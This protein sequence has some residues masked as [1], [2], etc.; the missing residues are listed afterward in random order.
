MQTEDDTE[1]MEVTIEAAPAP[2]PPAEKKPIEFWA[3]AKGYLPQIFNGS[4]YALP[5]GAP[6]DR[7]GGSAVAL[8]QLAGPRANPE[9]WRFAAAKAGSKWP[10]NLEITEADFEAAV[11]LATNGHQLR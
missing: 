4:T 6:V 2:A 9:F 5:G 7:M 10:E 8:G 11:E 3:T 1:A